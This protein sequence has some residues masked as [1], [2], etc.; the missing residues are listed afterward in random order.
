MAEKRIVA[1]SLTMTSRC[2]RLSMHH[3][4][5]YYHNL[6]SVLAQQL[7]AVLQ[8]ASKSVSYCTQQCKQAQASLLAST[9]LQKGMDLAAHQL[10]CVHCNMM[11]LGAFQG[12]ARAQECAGEPGAAQTG[13]EVVAACLASAAQRQ[14]VA[15]CAEQAAVVA[16]RQRT[17]WTM[18][19][20]VAPQQDCH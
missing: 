11:V 10:C 13:A 20:R 19:A 16:E 12:A 2:V 18:W 5:F 15:V 8:T 17:N 4:L 6:Q 14:G 3:C 1:C 9:G 7:I